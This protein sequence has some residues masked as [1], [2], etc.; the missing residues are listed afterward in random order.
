MIPNNIFQILSKINPAI[1]NLQSISTPD[2]MAQYLLNTGK[3]NQNQ[4]NHVR[5]MWGNP[6]I[7]QMIQNRFGVK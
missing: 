7:Q 4:V 5:Q 3:V 2:D 1:E 6:Q